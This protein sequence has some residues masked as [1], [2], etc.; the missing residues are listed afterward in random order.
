MIQMILIIINV[1]ASDRN[2]IPAHC[3]IDL[4]LQQSSM[5]D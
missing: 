4:M 1:Y 5:W 3:L 2:I